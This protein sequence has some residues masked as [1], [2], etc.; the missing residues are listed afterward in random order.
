MALGDKQRAIDELERAYR[1]R[2]ENLP[3]SYQSR[4]TARSTTRRSAFRGAGAKDYPREIV[5][6]DNCGPAREF[7]FLEVVFVP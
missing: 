3:F 6:I 7:A 1:E 5:I 4:S 2:A